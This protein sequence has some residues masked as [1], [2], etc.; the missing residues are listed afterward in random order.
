MLSS[1]AAAARDVETDQGP[2][3]GRAI[4]ASALPGEGG[5]AQDVEAS[6]PVR[7]W[8]PLG[9]VPIF[10]IKDTFLRFLGDQALITGESKHQRKILI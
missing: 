10:I 2:R 7:A 1:D 5:A 4:P 3:R 8:A 9:Q 6:V